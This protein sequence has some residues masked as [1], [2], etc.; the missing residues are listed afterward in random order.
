[1]KKLMTMIAAA[2][3]AFGL[4]AADSGFIAGAGFDST[5]TTQLESG[6]KYT[7]LTS[8]FVTG[9]WTGDVASTTT[10]KEEKPTGITHPLQFDDDTGRE[11]DQVL[12]IKTT[13]GNP[14][15]QKI[16]GSAVDIGY[17]L[18][19]DGLVNMTVFDFDDTPAITG[20]AFA[21]AKV[22]LW[23]QL[24]SGAEGAD[25]DLWIAAA[26]ND[27]KAWKTA[28]KNIGDAWH[29]VTIKAIKNIYKTGTPAVG[30]V[31]FVDGNQVAAEGSSEALVKANLTPEAKR[32]ADD[33]SL[34]LSLTDSTEISEVLFDGQG[35]IDEIAFTTKAP[36]FAEDTEFCQ[37]TGAANI[38][39]FT[40]GGQIWNAGEDALD[41]E[42]I[43][44]IAVTAIVAADDYFCD[45]T[46]TNI[47]GAVKGQTYTVGEAK[48]LGAY[49]KIGDNDPIPCESVAAAMAEVNKEATTGAVTL[50][51][52]DASDAI[53]LTNPEVN[54]TLDL[55]GK[56]ITATDA[57][58]AAVYAENGS[59]KIINS[60]D[61]LGIVD[62]TA[63]ECAVDFDH[64]EVL[65][66]KGK[67][68]AEVATADEGITGGWFDAAPDA[69]FIAEGLK[70]ELDEADGWYKIVEDTSVTVTFA[71]GVNCTVTAI[72]G[73]TADSTTEKTAEIGDTFQVTY[74]ANEGYEY[75]EGASTKTL[76]VEVT[77][78][79]AQAA[80]VAAEPTIKTFTVTFVD[81]KVTPPEQQ[82]VNYGAKATNPG[83]AEKV[84]KF[85]FDGWFAEGAQTAFDFDTVITADVT[86]TAQYTR[87]AFV[88]TI[89]K[90]GNVD[91]T[92]NGDGT[93][94]FTAATGSTLASLV[95]FDDGTPLAK[96]VTSE[97]EWVWT[98][99][100]TLEKDLTVVIAANVIP[101]KPELKWFQ[102]FHAVTTQNVD[103]AEGGG[104]M[105]GA[106][107][108]GM[109]D[110]FFGFSVGQ[111]GTEGIRLYKNGELF[112]SLDWVTVKTS[113]IFNGQSYALRG[114]AISKTRNLAFI[115]NYQNSDTAYAKSTALFAPLDVSWVDDLSKCRPVTILDQDGETELAASLDCAAFSSDGKFL[116]ASILGG[117]VNYTEN[118]GWLGKFAVGND[119]LTLV[120]RV[121]FGARIRSFDFIDKGDREIAIVLL[122]KQIG[123]KAV[124]FAEE[125]A[126]EESYT[127]YTLVG[128]NILPVASYGG[129]TISGR[130]YDTQHLTV[131]TSDNANSDSDVINVYE[132]GIPAS[133]AIT[134]TEIK[135]F[136]QAK[137]QSCGMA[138]NKKSDGHC[139][140]IAVTDDEKTL[141]YAYIT[142]EVFATKGGKDLS[143][144]CY[145]CVC[146]EEEVIDPVEPG[147]PT[148][149]IVIPGGQTAADAAAAAFIENGGVVVPDDVKAALDST[150]WAEYQALF[151]G[152]ATPTGNENE[153]TFS[154]VLKDDVVAD[155]EDAVADGCESIVDAFSS[156][157]PA[158]TI[159][160]KP[161]LWYGVAQDGALANMAAKNP[162]AWTC[163]N[164]ETIT[165]PF[166]KSGDAQFYRVKCVVT[167]PA[168]E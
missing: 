62:G 91:Y 147:K 33:E 50:K 145:V 127:L 168:V 166:T 139:K 18:Y 156:E 76:T 162:A 13:P 152:K 146:D 104:N 151:T 35:S 109:Q 114:I 112:G 5:D 99:P 107:R 164:G 117:N 19:F 119:T 122:N 16:G 163:G 21:N 158:A 43:D 11:Y 58:E 73:E 59:I 149:P 47:T 155:I 63:C 100:E 128:E 40:V 121:K 142:T 10:I 137:I 69:S 29:R 44:P 36:T 124:D 46:T 20:D 14:I 161:G 98:K 132:L 138:V 78:E 1:M 80:P 39:S 81:D 60:T 42:V 72:D 2:A 25:A 105:N 64:G 136:N 83:H 159:L 133:G 94:T 37:I 113:E 49:L 38:K 67:F 111:A 6:G 74:T 167:K 165:V 9:W 75:A 48:K 93:V 71:N 134:A 141:Y 110:E 103:C 92:D 61:E 131:A 96:E 66:E 56:T 3:M 45:Y 12:A 55:A 26:G 87:D 30:F 88:L 116:Y 8:G 148:K 157:E 118:E 125:A 97:T 135:T 130:M 57:D 54:L 160:T 89:S 86:L 23:L 4:Y 106:Y 70:P 144:K 82:V 95:D 52:N 126:D 123:I 15:G 115:N 17:G 140:A 28:T 84:G 150:K 79:G 90:V 41:V 120:K 24:A 68:I 31:V 143:T 7:W 77:A 65:I 102:G 34:F 53:T 101:V 22:G 32:W 154:P 51:M 129:L 108:A 85:T 153:Y 27:A